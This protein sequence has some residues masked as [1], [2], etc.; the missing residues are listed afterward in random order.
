MSKEPRPFSL[1]SRSSRRRRAEELARCFAA[2]GDLY[3]A[4]YERAESAS[5]R[6]ACEELGLPMGY[7]RVSALPEL[8]GEE[9]GDKPR[10][11]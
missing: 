9:H 5:I 10:V 3:G 1:L 8:R 7:G 2:L 4:G 11:K 6:E